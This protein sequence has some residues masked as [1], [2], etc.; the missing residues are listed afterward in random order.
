MEEGK[1]KNKSLY[2]KWWFWV[3]ILV[4][5]ITIAFTSIIMLGFAMINPDENLSKLAKDLQ[6]YDNNITVY[7]SAGK[8]TI[9]IDCL[10][11]KSDEMSQKSKDIGEICG[12]HISYL[13]MYSEIKFELHTKEGEKETFTFDIKNQDIKEEEIQSWLMKGSTA[14]NQEEE[15]VKELQKKQESLNAEI[16]GLESKKSSLNSELEKL[17]GDVVKIKGESKKYPAGHLTAGTDVPVGKYKIYGGNSNFVVYSSSGD[18]KVNIILGGGYGVDEYIYTFQNGD[19]IQSNSSFM[20]V[21]V[22]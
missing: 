6:E 13:T 22:E 11:E 15:K 10:S 9:L 8:N 1:N 4:I 5:I 14:F 18:L 7:Q 3:I 17:S 12:K 21:P 16:S 2:K 20:L 19:K